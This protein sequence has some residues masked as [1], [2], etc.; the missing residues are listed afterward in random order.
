MQIN[1]PKFLPNSTVVFTM[2]GSKIIVTTITSSIWTPDGTG[3][4]YFVK[5]FPGEF[6]ESQLASV[7]EYFARNNIVR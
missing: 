5:D 4:G 1:F 3:W 6:K 2:G 7:T